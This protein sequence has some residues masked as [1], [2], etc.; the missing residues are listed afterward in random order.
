MSSRRAAWPYG[1]LPT[2]LLVAAGYYAIA[3]VT[4][5]QLFLVDWDVVPVWPAAGWAVASRVHFKR[6]GLAGI[7]LGATMFEWPRMTGF[8][9][10]LVLAGV[11]LEA[12]AGARLIEALGKGGHVWLRQARDLPVL[13]AVAAV[14]ATLS[15]TLGAAGMCLS[16]RAAW[17]LFPS[18]WLVHWLG[19]SLGIL[20]VTP[21]LLLFLGTKFRMGRRRLAEL[22]VLALTTVG[23]SHAIFAGWLPA[24]ES[25]LAGFFPLLIWASLRF[26]PLGASSASLT[27]SAFALW[28]TTHGIGP[29]AHG[30]SHHQMAVLWTFLG[31]VVGTTYLF[32][33]VLEERRYAQKEVAERESLLRSF[34]DGSPVMMGIVETGADDL[35]FVSGNAALASFLGRPVE[36]IQGRTGRELGL[37]EGHSKLWLD[38][39]RESRTEAR[40]IR[41]EYCPPEHGNKTLAATVHPIEGGLF[42]RCSFVLE[43]LTERARAQRELDRFFASSPEMLCIAG[44]DGLLKRVNPAFS[45]TLGRSSS[46]L[47][48]R[49]FIQ[50]IHPDDREKVLREVERIGSGAKTIDLEVRCRRGDG[51]Y[52]WYSWTAMGERDEGL[53]YVNGRDVTDAKVAAET[54]RVAKERAEAA[55]RAKSEFVANMSHELRTPLSAIIGLSDLIEHT[56]L[57]PGQREYLD[58]IRQ[59]AKVLLLLVNDILDFAKIESGKIEIES[60]PFDLE[61]LVTGALRP[62]AYQAHQKG[63][64]LVFRIDANVPNEVVGD[65]TRLQQVVLNLVSNAIKFTETGY[66]AVEVSA[67]PGP[68]DVELDIR[69]TDTGVGIAEESRADVFESF[70]QADGSTTRKYGGTGLG[71]AISSQLVSLMGGSIEVESEVGVG[72]TFRF[73]VRVGRVLVGGDD[74]EA[75]L[76][77]PAHV[78]V[79][80][81]LPIVREFLVSTL[82]SSDIGAAGAGGGEE[83][84]F[85]VRDARRRGRPFGVAFVSYSSFVDGSSS[86]LHTLR[87]EEPS[88]RFVLLTRMTDR[89]PEDYRSELGVVGRLVKPVAPQQLRRALAILASAGSARDEETITDTFAR[90]TRRPQRILVA[91]DDPINR[92]VTTKLLAKAGHDVV[93]AANGSEALARA[94]EESFDLVF[95]DLQMPEM[96]GLQVAAKIR[97]LESARGER[98]TP[99]VALTANARKEDRDR[100]LESGMDGYLAKPVDRTRLLAAAKN[101]APPGSAPSSPGDAT[102]A[103]AT[104]ELETDSGE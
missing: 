90:E 95:M 75:R 82:Q 74:S 54:L 19:D 13:G 1:A 35:V 99:I 48:S 68:A 11:V 40:A 18:K 70:V 51:T 78:L 55:T 24:G 87:A 79:V 98:R 58:G 65:P 60:T 31:V 32:A 37:A 16:G 73:N 92:M 20:F 83:V 4:L 59:S 45:K 81:P 69:I 91:D 76:P 62:L 52:R 28:G 5:T 66:V 8:P 104:A 34:Y 102:A 33:A 63:L 85:A 72:S 42:P 56:A 46:E 57:G 39:C 22:S 30:N 61:K 84:L 23:L 41:F 71:L 26:G 9:L 12:I 94:Q 86:W 36:S 27:I 103:V 49:P 17:F 29:L 64:E 3:H 101:F 89:L 47:M 44:S 6:R 80:D 7:V 93:G 50:W 25:A 38:K 67:S 43:D 53:I 77:E 96:D 10:L 2:I 88:L 14:A 97:E 100:C 15:A 21:V